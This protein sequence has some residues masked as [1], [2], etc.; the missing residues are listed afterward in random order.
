MKMIGIW[1]ASTL[2][3]AAS[4]TGDFISLA[5]QRHGAFGEKAAK[6]LVQNMPEQDKETLPV[7]FL[8]ENLERNLP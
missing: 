4:A 2:L 3:V 7:D 8:M 6:F 5:A 1:L